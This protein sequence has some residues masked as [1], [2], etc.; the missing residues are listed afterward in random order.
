MNQSAKN[1]PSLILASASPRRRDLL[2]R[3]GYVFEICVPDIEEKPRADESPEQ[4]VERNACEKALAVDAAEAW[5]LAADTVV[6]HG[7]EILEKPADASM[8]RDMLQQL[9]GNKHRVLTGFAL[10][11]GQTVVQ[12]QVVATEVSF[13]DVSEEEISRYVAGGEPLD[14]AGAYAIQGGAAGMVHRIHGS[15][16]NVVGLPLSDVEM[17]LAEVWGS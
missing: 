11:R 17:A 7:M 5:V 14:K 8:A 3:T 12:A 1:Q 4:Y 16:T 15:Y 10:A 13:R 9:S 6:V 2:V